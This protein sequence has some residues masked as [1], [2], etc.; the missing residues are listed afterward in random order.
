MENPDG[1]G[2]NEDDVTG[3]QHTNYASPEDQRDD[4]RYGIDNTLEWKKARQ[5]N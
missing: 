1:N 5:R 3:V 2:Y 4:N